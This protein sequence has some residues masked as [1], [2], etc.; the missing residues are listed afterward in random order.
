MKRLLSLLILLVLA[1]TLTSCSV[2]SS[3]K[4]IR[5]GSV[6][7]STNGRI[8]HNVYSFNGEATYKIKVKNDRSLSFNGDISIKNGEIIVLIK[9][10][11]DNELYN[12]T[13]TKD[14]S[15]KVDLDDYGRYKIIVTAKDFEGCYEFTW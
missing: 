9:D 14:E 12:E 6:Y 1:F 13:L 10:S 5:I 3:I 2:Q 4:G 11:K 15:I 7:I 8:Y